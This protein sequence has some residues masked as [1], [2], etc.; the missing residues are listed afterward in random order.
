VPG[1]ATRFYQSLAIIVSRRLRETSALIPF[2]MIEDVAQVQRSRPTHFGLS[3]TNQLPPSLMKAID[4]FKNAMMKAEMS[5]IKQNSDKE[6]VH[7]LISDACQKMNDS[8]RVH[9]ER[10]ES[11]AKTVGVTVFRE[12]F[13]FFMSSRFLDRC[14]TKPRGFAGDFETINQIYDNDP[15]GEGR[16]GYYID[17]WSLEIPACKAVRE[18]RHFM[19]KF[20]HQKINDFDKESIPIAT[21]A[22]GPA[23]EMFDIFEE[24]FDLEVQYTCVDIDHLALGLVSK[25]MKEKRLEQNIRIFKENIVRMS[26]GKGKITVPP[27]AIIYSLGLIDY[28]QDKLVIKLLDWIFNNLSPGGYSVL[29]NFNKGNPDKPFMD[30]VVEWVLIH[31]SPEDL[32]EIYSKSKFGSRVVTISTDETGVQLFASCQKS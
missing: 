2:L 3:N 7:L 20:I 5:I 16:L 12:T 19:K 11:L 24:N 1:L 28:L 10:E 27:Q 6:Q 18:R 4:A 25:K 29:G 31:R 9:V 15:H 23:R 21:L 8:L 30:Y 26:L 13:P 22:C 32:K 17:N 14:F